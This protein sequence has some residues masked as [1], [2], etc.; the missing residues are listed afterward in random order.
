M[1]TDQVLLDRTQSSYGNEF[2]TSK[3]IQRIFG[4]VNMDLITNTT[5]EFSNQ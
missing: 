1:I 5:Q 2:L 4:C 3:V